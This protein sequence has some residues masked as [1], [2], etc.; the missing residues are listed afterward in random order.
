MLADSLD[1]SSISGGLRKGAHHYSDTLR[2]LISVIS[3]VNKIEGWRGHPG[4]DVCSFLA[5]WPRHETVLKGH[6]WLG[7]YI[8]KTRLRDDPWIF[9]LGIGVSFWSQ[10]GCAQVGPICFFCFSLHDLVV[11]MKVA[12]QGCINDY[13][14][15]GILDSEFAAIF[16]DFPFIS[17]WVGT[18]EVFLDA[19]SPLVTQFFHSRVLNNWLL[20]VEAAFSR[21]SRRLN[22]ASVPRDTWHL[23]VRR[24]QKKVIR[25]CYTILHHSSLRMS[26]GEVQGTSVDS[27]TVAELRKFQYI[28]LLVRGYS[29]KEM[30]RRWSSLTIRSNLRA[31]QSILIY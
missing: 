27:L 20:I 25:I 6:N 2:G 13:V 8:V 22:A 24:R 11:R 23:G 1:E 15:L 5:T 14:C 9:H 31:S 12:Y 7:S 29:L 10:K 26:L 18:Y 19:I 28:I 30:R 3:H 21:V 17:D 4:L 16:S